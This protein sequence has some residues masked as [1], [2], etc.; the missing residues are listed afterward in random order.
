MSMYRYVFFFSVNEN[1]QIAKRF[2]GKDGL[3]WTPLMMAAS[4]PNGDG[5][6]LVDKLLRKGAD[7]GM[8]SM[9]GLLDFTER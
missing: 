9:Y 5:D 1:V 3:G 2:R 8:K 6:E 7:V 4:L